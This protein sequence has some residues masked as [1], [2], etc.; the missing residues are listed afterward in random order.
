[1]NIVRLDLVHPGT[2]EFQVTYGTITARIKIDGLD[3]TG[4]PEEDSIEWRPYYQQRL[5][6]LFAAI[7]AEG[8]DWTFR[9]SN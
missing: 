2:A 5:E 3:T 1:M 4:G 7:Q 9:G 6:E 8:T